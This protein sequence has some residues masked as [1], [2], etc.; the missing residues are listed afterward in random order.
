MKE[1]TAKMK[2]PQKLATI[3]SSALCAVLFICANTGSSG[4]IHQPK[5]PA[6]LNR[7]S[8]FK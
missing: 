3:L 8:K 5:A 1:I 4:M 2:F 7:F 6:D